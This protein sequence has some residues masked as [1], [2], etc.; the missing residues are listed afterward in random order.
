MRVIALVGNETVIFAVAAIVIVVVTLLVSAVGLTRRRR[1]TQH[2]LFTGLGFM[3][4]TPPPPD[5]LDRIAAL[6]PHGRRERLHINDV[7][8]RAI[9]GGDA[10]LFDLVDDDSEGQAWAG[11]RALA[12]VVPSLALPF[13]ALQP[14]LRLA[15]RLGGLLGTALERAMMFATARAGLV[16]VDYPDDLEFGERFLVIGKSE[17]EVRG[18]LTGRRRTALLELPG[19]LMLTTNEDT[20]ALSLVSPEA[21]DETATASVQVLLEAAERVRLLLSG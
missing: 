13:V 9:S 19:A 6:Q 12:V 20:F 21:S 17:P 4:V 16:Q 15:E 18:L 10:Y 8:H 3:P 7:Y 14:K 11:G 5:L 1:A 2:D